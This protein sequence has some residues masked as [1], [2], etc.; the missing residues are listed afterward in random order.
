MLIFLRFDEVDYFLSLP[1]LPLVT[2]LE[3]SD[4]LRIRRTSF[5]YGQIFRQ[6]NSTIAVNVVVTSHL[7]VC[8]HSAAGGKV[9]R[10][11]AHSR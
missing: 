2:K 9:N 3:Q 7:P 8:L 4:P 6:H 11:A 5:G 1:K 10:Q